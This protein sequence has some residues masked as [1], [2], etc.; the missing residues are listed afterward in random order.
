[1][2]LSARQAG[3]LV[4]IE[5]A[6][7]GRGIDPE[8]MR[9]TALQRG[10][11]DEEASG[12]LDDQQAIELIF[13]SGFST[14]HSVSDL[15]GRG[16][17]MD[18]VRSSVARLGGALTIESAKGAGSRVSL[19]LPLAMVMTKVMVVRAG[20]ER[21]GVPMDGIS[22]TARIDPAR[23][24]AVREGRA[25][26]LRDRTV[27]LFDLAA[28][29]GGAAH[30]TGAD[31]VTVLVFRH[32]EGLAAVSVDGVVDRIDVVMRPLTGLMSH[33]RGVSG[34]TLMGDGDILMLLDLE[35]MIG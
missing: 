27:P 30:S 24:V 8:A 26:V 16:V 5:V 19:S 33:M 6:D 2:T 15:S 17:G 23:V 13:L 32:G 18:A 34:A 35:G 9:R 28:L 14:A 1:M 20:G 31:D 22:E 3:E 11:M 4:V 12:A 10:L 29:T 25:F 21:F 7:D